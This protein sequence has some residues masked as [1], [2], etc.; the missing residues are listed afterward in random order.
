MKI[1][2]N[3][4]KCFG[5]LFCD[6]LK[7]RGM[8]TILNGE[9]AGAFFV[10][11]EEENRGNTLVSLLGNDKID[12]KVIIKRLDSEYNYSVAG[13]QGEYAGKLIRVGCIGEL[14]KE[15][16]VNLVNAIKTIVSTM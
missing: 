2:K 4:L 13:G 3:F 11:I 9:Y 12:T 5:K 6:E 8:Y 16:I 15:D 7:Y 14:T 10:Y 1:M